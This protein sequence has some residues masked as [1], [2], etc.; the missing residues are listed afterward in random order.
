MIGKCERCGKKMREDDLEVDEDTHQLLCPVKVRTK[1]TDKT[2]EAVEIA[3]NEINALMIYRLDKD[4]ML[5]HGQR[6]E[7]MMDTL[8]HLISIA[9]RVDEGKILDIL[10][11]NTKE[12]KGGM[13]NYCGCSITSIGEATKQIVNYLEGKNG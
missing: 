1:M 2:K 10:E 13:G 3:K 12:Q 11:E 7:L 9:E 5:H 8:T 4:F 6:T